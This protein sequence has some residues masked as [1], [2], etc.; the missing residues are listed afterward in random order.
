MVW[1]LMRRVADRCA[2]M[3]ACSCGSHSVLGQR[4]ARAPGALSQAGRLKRVQA[5][6]N[7]DKRT[8]S[9][10]LKQLLTWLHDIQNQQ[11][12]IRASSGVRHL[13]LVVSDIWVLQRDVP[14]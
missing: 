8:S 11:E 2:L 1:V 5:E 7:W 3:S 6:T 13:Y 14:P 9:E 12:D 10:V 4:Q